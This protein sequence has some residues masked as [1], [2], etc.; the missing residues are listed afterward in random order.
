ML[1][2]IIGIIFI[3]LLLSLLAT[4][5]NELLASWRNWRG[6]YLD[7]GLRKL[8]E[9]NNDDQPYNQFVSNPL[10]QQLEKH[11]LF[12]RVSRAPSYLQN[13]TFSSILFTVL[14]EKHKNSL[15]LDDFINALPDDSRLRSTLEDVESKGNEVANTLK[16]F[17]VKAKNK[18]EAFDN[19]NSY[20]A[21]LPE[22]SPSRTALEKL[23]AGGNNVFDDIGILQKVLA[24]KNIDGILNALPK[25]GKLERIL[26]Q[27]KEEAG[28]ELNE[29]KGKV[30]NWFDE[31]MSRSAGW[32]KRHLQ[33]ITLMVGFGIAAFFNADTFRI[34][35]HLSTNSEAR[36]KVAEIATNFVKNNEQLPE[37][38]GENAKQ[39]QSQINSILKEDIGKIKNPLGLGWEFEEVNGVTIVKGDDINDPVGSWGM[40]ILGWLITALAISMGAPFWFDILKRIVNI[41]GAGKQAN[42][43]KVIVNTQRVVTAND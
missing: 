29:F 39:I 4:T 5:I 26:N 9:F 43:T 28:D 3:F 36:Q 38:T 18:E 24:A 16:A 22:G 1:Q 12:M 15:T 27:L 21:K 6:H 10:Y 20:I 34:Y 30:D 11:K 33:I 19:L 13:S 42:E 23:K 2:I 7:E 8:L 41:K 32:Y 35:Q 14:R 37:I 40:R 25:D 31:V 17:L